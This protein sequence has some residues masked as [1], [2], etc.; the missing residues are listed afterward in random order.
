LEEDHV[1]HIRRILV[2]KETQGKEHLEDTEVDGGDEFADT[3]ETGSI[4]VE[5]EKTRY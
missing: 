3:K 5:M 4:F 2:V 1:R